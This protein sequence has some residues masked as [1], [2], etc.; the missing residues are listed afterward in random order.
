[1][2]KPQAPL[3]RQHGKNA[4]MFVIVTVTLDMMGFGLIVPVIPSLLKEVMELDPEDA[5][6]WGGALTATYALMNFLATPTLGN[7]SDRF[8]RRP[9]LLAS[10]GTLAIDFLIMGFANTC[11][12]LLLGRA[13]SGISSSTFSTA[14]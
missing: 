10:I 6:A 2:P 11:W 8:G 3:T 14:N 5:V 12:V 1:M 13:L 9:I 7:L 4:F